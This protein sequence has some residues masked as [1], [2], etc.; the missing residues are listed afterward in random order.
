MY[1]LLWRSVPKIFPRPRKASDDFLKF[2]IRVTNASCDMVDG[3]CHVAKRMKWYMGLHALF[4]ERAPSTSEENSRRAE[5]R[6]CL[7]SHIRELYCSLLYYEMQCV[8]YCYRGNYMT[9][10]LRALVALDDWKGGSDPMHIYYLRSSFH[11]ALFLTES[12]NIERLSDIKDLE[13]RIQADMTQFANI[14]VQDGLN[15]AAQDYERIFADIDRSV[16]RFIESQ[17]QH[18]NIQQARDLQALVGRFNTSDY[19]KQMKLNPTRVPGTC[20]WFCNHETFKK[21]LGTDA[22]LL[23]V[24]ADPG[25]GKSTLARYLIEEVL[26]QQSTECKVSFKTLYLTQL[27][28]VLKP[29]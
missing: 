17:E 10:T 7:R 12:V 26:P 4:L 13:A 21:W 15:K 8:C 20:E 9:R 29:V 16:Q 1:A 27:T 25:C 23:L 28:L 5:L 24:S 18:S 22:G 11:A 6:I 2:S 3:L 19:K 14:Q